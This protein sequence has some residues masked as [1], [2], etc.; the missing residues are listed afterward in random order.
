[1]SAVS[2][3]LTANG[4]EHEETGGGCTAWTKGDDGSWYW[5]I[6][7]ADDPS[8]PESMDEPVTVGQYRLDTMDPVEVVEYPSL[9]HWA[10]S[11]Y[12]A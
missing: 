3:L 4:W 7:R 1:M 8:A 12:L 10:D 9:R 11:H 6:T 5:M 2:D